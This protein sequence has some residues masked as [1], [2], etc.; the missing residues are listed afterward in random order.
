M[1]K[2]KNSEKHKDERKEQEKRKRKRKK[3]APFQ[4]T[5]NLANQLF[6]PF[7]EK[8]DQKSTKEK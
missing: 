4:E 2:K 5:R 3:V 1:R 7:Q 6:W 8:K